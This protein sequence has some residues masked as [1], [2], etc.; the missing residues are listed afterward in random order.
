MDTRDSFSGALLEPVFKSVG[1]EIYCEM[2]PLNVTQPFSNPTQMTAPGSELDQEARSN[3]DE[4]HL[5]SSSAG[6]WKH[7]LGDPWVDTSAYRF[8]G[9]P[10]S[11][12][13][14]QAPESGISVGSPSPGG[15]IMPASKKTKLR[16]CTASVQSLVFDDLSTEYSQLLPVIEHPLTAQESLSAWAMSCVEESGRISLALKLAPP[17]SKRKDVLN[18][19]ELI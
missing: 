11:L 8:S 6:R 14:S 12:T 1:L 17:P 18:G 9:I 15:H 16:R 10:L 13:C 19:N 7:D 3:G 5:C 4:P 2:M